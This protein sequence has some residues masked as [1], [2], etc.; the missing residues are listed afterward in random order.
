MMDFSP[1]L[2]ALP[3]LGARMA[4]GVDA[5]ASGADPRRE[6]GRDV[7]GK[8]AQGRDARGTETSQRETDAQ[9]NS[10]STREQR[11]VESL[12]RRDREVRAHEAAHLAAAGG[13]ARGGA[14][15]EYRRGP[16]GG[17]YA[18][19]GEVGID[20]SPVAGDPAATLAKAETVRRAALAPAEPSGQD[21]QVANQ[22]AAMAAQARQ[23]LAKEQR[24]GGGQGEGDAD[25]DPRRGAGDWLRDRIQASGSLDLPAHQSDPLH[26]VA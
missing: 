22:A 4:P 23:E 5:R 20:T 12:Q 6:H 25:A 19:G 2:T 16:D 15:F 7:Q 17:S 3:S 13:Y 18:V 1:S 9:G 26:L 10:L 24:L 8:E 21:R 11:Q 14:Q